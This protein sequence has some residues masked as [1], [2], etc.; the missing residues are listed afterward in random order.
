MSSASEP[1]DAD[2]NRRCAV[3]MDWHHMPVILIST[4]EPR[5]EYITHI[6]GL[7]IPVALWSPFT[8]AK[9][10][11]IL[12]DRLAD[13][14]KFIQM[15]YNHLRNEWWVMIDYQEMASIDPDR[16]RAV[17]KAYLREVDATEPVLSLS[18]EWCGSCEVVHTNPRDCADEAAFNPGGY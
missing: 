17:V 10:N 3:S 16:K 15:G 2:L 6:P 7:A 11:E 5:D 4:G 12:L 8:N 1:S 9:H 18:G 14:G 13:L